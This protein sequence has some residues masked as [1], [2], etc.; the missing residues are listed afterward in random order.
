MKAPIKLELSMLGCTV[1]IVVERDQLFLPEAE[2]ADRFLRPALAVLLRGAFPE[3]W[4]R[5]RVEIESEIAKVR[6][7][8]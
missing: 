8:G 5:E 7:P 3:K 6:N 2:L 1:D 4:Q